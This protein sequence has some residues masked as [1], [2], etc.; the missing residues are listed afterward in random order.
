[1]EHDHPSTPTPRRS[2][3]LG[4]IVGMAALTGTIVGVS[5]VAGAQADPTTAPAETSSVDDDGAVEVMSIDDADFA[6]FDDCMSEQLG[7]LWIEPIEFDVEMDELDLGEFDIDERELDEHELAELQEWTEADEQAFEA[8]DE[9]CRDLLPADLQ[10]ELAEWDAY[11]T[12]VGDLGGFEDDLG[13]A[14]VFVETGDG[15]QIVNFGELEGSVTITGSADG[16]TVST[17]GGVTVLDEAALDAQWAE[18]GAAH[19]ACEDLLPEDVFEED[20]GFEVTEVEGTD[21]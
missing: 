21:S 20:M 11:D 13:E 17:D 4:A 18:F 1:M 16:V 6:A 10:A 5:T 14:I 19:E 12:C 7:D 8:A 9:A 3:I 2:A 15:S